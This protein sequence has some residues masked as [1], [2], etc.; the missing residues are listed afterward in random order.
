[1]ISASNQLLTNDSVS[2]GNF[3]STAEHHYMAYYKHKI[4]ATAYV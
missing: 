3:I 4:N 2:K 1:M